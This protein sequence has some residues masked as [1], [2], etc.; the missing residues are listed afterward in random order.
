MEP[1][2]GVDPDTPGVPGRFGQGDSVGLGDGLVFGSMVDGFALLPG[3]GGFVEFEP[4]TPV[5]VVGL[6]FVGVDVLPG[7]VAVPGVWLCPE[8]AGLP[9]GGVPPDGALCATAR[10]ALNRDIDSK[11]SFVADI[12]EPPALRFQVLVTTRL[13]RIVESL[14]H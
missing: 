3:I 12:G 1:G 14:R 7:G 2:L 4:G 9:V 13:P 10:T 11:L 8:L 6:G 5:G